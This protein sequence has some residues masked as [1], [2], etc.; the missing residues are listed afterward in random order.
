MQLSPFLQC[1]THRILSEWSNGLDPDDSVYRLHPAIYIITLTAAFLYYKVT[2]EPAVLT[3]LLRTRPEQRRIYPNQPNRR[4]T[5]EFGR[6]FD[7]RVHGMTL[8]QR[9][10]WQDKLNAIFPYS[11]TRQ[12]CATALIHEV[13]DHG[14]HLHAQVGPLEI[15]PDLQTS[16]IT[17]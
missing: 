13:G 7:M 14:S 6:A 15:A 8:Q 12:G 4:S 2:G 16:I 5:H 17:V 9:Q 1:K 3:C 11:S 10:A